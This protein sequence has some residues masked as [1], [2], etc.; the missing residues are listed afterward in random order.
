MSSNTHTHQ[1]LP[2]HAN[3]RGR[4]RRVQVFTEAP[5]QADSV[6]VGIY[7]SNDGARAHRDVGNQKRRRIDP[8]QLDDPLAQ[9]TPVD[10][11]EN[12]YNG[13]NDFAD[14][15]DTSSSIPGV[16]ADDERLGKR[17]RYLS[18]VSILV[19]S[20]SLL[21]LI[22]LAGPAHVSLDSRSPRPGVPR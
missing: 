22:E 16:V 4:P 10:D 6:D 20:I 21:V 9:W 12:F 7:V 18:S 13:D 1:I 17:K 11:L 3:R 2:S 14:D 5:L 15:E 8:S 19:F